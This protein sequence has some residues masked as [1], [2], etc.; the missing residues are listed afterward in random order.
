MEHIKKRKFTLLGILI[1][2]VYGLLIWP[3]P[4][5]YPLLTH[6]LVGLIV[7]ILSGV[8]A[9]LDERNEKREK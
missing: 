6:H 1:V 2:T 8:L 5:H 3:Y 4:E 9:Y 7:L